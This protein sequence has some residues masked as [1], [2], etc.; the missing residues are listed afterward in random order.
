L[1]TA[2]HI[3][4]DQAKIGRAQAVRSP[5]MNGQAEHIFRPQPGSGEGFFHSFTLYLKG[6]F[7]A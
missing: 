4:R 3:I 6:F 7:N 1:E 2:T 5:L